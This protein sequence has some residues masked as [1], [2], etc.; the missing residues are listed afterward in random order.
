[1]IAVTALIAAFLAAREATYEKYYVR[2]FTE[3]TPFSLVITTSLV[4]RSQ[5]PS[6]PES[7]IKLIVEPLVTDDVTVKA[8][9]IIV[10]SLK[11]VFC[12][13][14]RETRNAPDERVFVETVLPTPAGPMVTSGFE[15]SN[16]SYFISIRT[17]ASLT[18]WVAKTIGTCTVWVGKALIFAM[19]TAGC[20]D[21][22]ADA[23]TTSIATIDNKLCFF[24]FGSPLSFTRGCEFAITY[25][26]PIKPLRAFV[27]YPAVTFV[28]M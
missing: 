2:Q 24:I 5:A 16:G 20:D 4:S 21:A 17:V 22:N 11:G 14:N 18:P 27:K 8:I 23:E 3:I 15:T 6:V 28:L 13:S 10:P 9:L 26:L 7:K 12:T 25:H 1:M 19:E